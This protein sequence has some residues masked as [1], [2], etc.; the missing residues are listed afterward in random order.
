MCGCLPPTSTTTAPMEALSFP[1]LEVCTILH[2]GQCFA[3]GLRVLM[4]GVLQH[5]CS[6]GQVR[7]SHIQN[8]CSFH[9]VAVKPMQI[10]RLWHVCRSC[11]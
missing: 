10:S 1:S 3:K 5:C 11:S 8:P 2:G 7:V 6:V 9:S 4:Y